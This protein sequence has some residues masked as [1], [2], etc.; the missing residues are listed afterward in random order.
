MPAKRT[1]VSFLAAVVIAT[2]TGFFARPF[3]DDNLVSVSEL[4][5]EDSPVVIIPKEALGEFLFYVGNL[6][7]A[8][9]ACQA[10]KSV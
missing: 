8:I 3:L 10:G 6:E 4:T 1:I 2:A 5:A 7:A 9:R